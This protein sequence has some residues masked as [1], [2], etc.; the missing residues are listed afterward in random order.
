MPDGD[1]FQAAPRTE[2]RTRAKMGPATGVN[3]V[4]S[5]RPSS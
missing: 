4:A 1:A 3:D 2:L 5:R